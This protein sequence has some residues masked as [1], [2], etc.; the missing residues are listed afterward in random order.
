[1]STTL[2]TLQAG[3]LPSGYCYPATPQELIN[4]ALAISSAVFGGEYQ[5]FNY[6][7]TKPAAADCTRPWIRTSNGNLEG[8]YAYNSSYWLRP[9]PIPASSDYRALWVGTDATIDTFDGGLVGAVTDFAGPMW[10]IDTGFAGRS[11]MGPGTLSL[12]LTAVTVANDFGVDQVTLDSTQIPAHTHTISKV[13]TGDSN[14]NASGSGTGQGVVHTDTDGVT[15]S[16]GGGLAHNNLHPV[17]GC[18][19][20]KRTA[21]IYY[22]QNP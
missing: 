17:R 15:G 3:S 12:S 9:H 8:L 19:I 14:T 4:D 10:A 11:P 6:G 20:I 13:H 7:D 18:Y 1:M 16:T 21:R 5:T 2:L 22:R